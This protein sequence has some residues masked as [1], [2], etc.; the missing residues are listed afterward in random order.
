MAALS[1][2]DASSTGLATLIDASNNSSRTSSAYATI[3]YHTARIL[4]AQGKKADARRLIDEMLDN[5]DQLP[6]SAR[7]SFLALRLTFAETLE[8]FLRYSLRK[9][10]AFDFGGQTGTIEEIIAEQ[11]KWYDPENQTQS[12]EAY[13]A[14]IDE[15]YRREREWQGR[16]M[17]DAE[18]IDVFNQHFP[19]AALV[20]VM[21]SPALP[22][23][24]RERFAV[25]IWMRAFL[26]ND[27]DLMVKATPELARYHPEFE[28]FLTKI[29]NARNPA[30]RNNAAL[31]FVIKNPL[32]SPFIEDGM[33]KTDNEF[34][35]F[36]SNDWWC[37]PYDT[38][39]NDAT[40]TVEPK[41]LPQRPSFLTVA[42]SQLAQDERE[43]LK[44]TGDAPKYLAEK[45]IEWARRYPTD[46][47]VP[48][49]MYMMI[50]ANGWTKY[51]CG[52]NEELRNKMTEH[53][54]RRYPNSE[55]TAKLDQD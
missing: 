44:E 34:A 23:Y 9:P 31:Y 2:A 45:V 24:L 38:E 1:K 8:D 53:L 12:R 41:S 3:A 5:G 13:E 14:E 43:R 52:N 51:G 16:M 26:L 19:T 54:R 10:F 32:L 33:G 36:D 49:A 20:E 17:F 35:A 29:T 42:Q 47:R 18:T 55:W 48:E 50:E 28:P 4:I 46:A 11:K 15:Q 6:L 30:A 27:I 40:D 22:D 39:Y 7:N 21:R 25:A 37:A